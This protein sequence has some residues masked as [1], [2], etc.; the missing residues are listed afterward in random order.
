[1]LRWIA[2]RGGPTSGAGVIGIEVMVREDTVL[3]A[4]EGG[5]PEKATPTEL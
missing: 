3:E 4:A 1:M 5:A 2:R